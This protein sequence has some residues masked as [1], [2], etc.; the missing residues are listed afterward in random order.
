[1]MFKQVLFN[2]FEY[3]LQQKLQNPRQNL[4]PNK[5]CLEKIKQT[6]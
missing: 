2:D 5:K 1:M 6:Y 3:M 4:E